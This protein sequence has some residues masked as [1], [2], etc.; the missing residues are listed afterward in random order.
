MFI[1]FWESP[2]N[3]V[4]YKMGKNKIMI[5]GIRQWELVSL[6]SYEGRMYIRYLDEYFPLEITTTFKPLI[7]VNESFFD[8]DDP[9]DF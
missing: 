4:G 1:E 3:S 6:A 2:L 9:L 7:P 8:E 5:Y